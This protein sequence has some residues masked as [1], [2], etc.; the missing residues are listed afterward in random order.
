MTVSS[1]VHVVDELNWPFSNGEPYVF[2]GG[3]CGSY[4]MQ[5]KVDPFPC[6]RHDHLVASIML[7][8]VTQKFPLHNPAQIYIL[9]YETLSRTNGWAQAAIGWYEDTEYDWESRIVFNGKRTP[10]H[11]AMTRYL[12]AHEYGHLVEYELLRQRGLN[13]DSDVIEE[14]YKEFRGGQTEKYGAR[15]WHTKTKEIFANDFRICVCGV[16]KE[17]WPHEVPYPTDDVIEWW[18]KTLKELS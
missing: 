3:E 10:I 9:E 18:N 5:E 7:S 6:Y 16:E 15:A 11:P 8:Q 17:F 12:V 14:E 1:K 2:I 13:A 4:K